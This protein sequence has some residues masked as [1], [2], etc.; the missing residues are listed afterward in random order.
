M[1]DQMIY[2]T[3]SPEE[4]FAL[5]RQ[6]AEECSPGD[7]FCLEG[8]L[9]VGKTLFSQG[10]AKGLGFEGYVNSPT[11]T[12][13]HIYEGGRLDMYHFDLY[14]IGDASEMDEIGYEDYFFGEGVSLVEWADL[15]PEIIPAEAKRILIEKDV[16]MGVNYRK[17]TV[18]TA[19]GK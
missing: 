18:E 10:F 9:G 19:G 15:F 8:D 16:S 7:I 17:I 1:S 13:V 6:M 4:T 2:E 3:H 12:I 5:A 11:F 14:R